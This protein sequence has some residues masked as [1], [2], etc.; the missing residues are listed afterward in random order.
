ME[1]GYGPVTDKKEAFWN[2]SLE[3]EDYEKAKKK[4]QLQQQHQKDVTFQTN[5][6]QLLHFQ[7]FS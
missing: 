2:V 6:K 4:K 1:R 5:C 7:S 3:S